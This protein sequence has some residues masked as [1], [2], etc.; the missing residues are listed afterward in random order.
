MRIF[1]FNTKN[2]FSSFFCG[3]LHFRRGV[4]CVGIM[5]DKSGS[6]YISSISRFFFLERYFVFSTVFETFYI[7]SMSN[8]YHR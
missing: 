5:F 7:F 4:H 6:M 8:D 2:A 1:D 3:N